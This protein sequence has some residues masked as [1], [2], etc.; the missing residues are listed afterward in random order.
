MPKYCKTL[1][2]NHPCLA[3]AAGVDRGKD[4]SLLQANVSVTPDITLGLTGLNR[5]GRDPSA[6]AVPPNGS[7]RFLGLLGNPHRRAHDTLWEGGASGSPSTPVGSRSGNGDPGQSSTAVEPGSPGSDE[8]GASSSGSG[9]ELRQ[10]AGHEQ[11]GLAAAAE[12]D[13]DRNGGGH[14]AESSRVRSHRPCRDLALTGVLF[15]S[16]LL[17]CLRGLRRNDAEIHRA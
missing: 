14:P 11:P 6:A 9:G 3:V 4:G 7:L 16:G 5:P 2:C 12:G 17:H 10:A 13:H 1:Q 15:S 8:S